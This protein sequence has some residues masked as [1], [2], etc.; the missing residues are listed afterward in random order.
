MNSRICSI[1]SSLRIETR[2]AQEGEPFVDAAPARQDGELLLEDRLVG[3]LQLGI[4]VDELDDVIALVHA[5][6]DQRIAGERAD[7]V[8]AGH[9]GFEGRRQHRIGDAV[10]AGELDAGAGHDRLLAVV[11]LEGGAA[12]LD[13]GARRRRA[14]PGDDPVALDLQLAV[15]RV[16]G[17]PALLDLGWRWS[18]AGW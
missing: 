12:A 2:R 15:A 6:L 8:D 16:E 3:G 14:H 1:D 17:D 10:G 4:A 9:G 11:L 13:E 7:H 5:M 18:R